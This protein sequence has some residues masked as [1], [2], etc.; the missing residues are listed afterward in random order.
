[1]M[2]VYI[3]TFK[4]AVQVALRVCNDL[5]LKCE[6]E[7]AWFDIIEQPALHSDLTSQTIKRDFN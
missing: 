2:F 4:N 1:M 5:L 7:L 3:K 6:S